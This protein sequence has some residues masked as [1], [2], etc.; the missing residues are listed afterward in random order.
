M[1][2]V[3]LPHLL[4]SLVFDF[5]NHLNL[6]YGTIAE[7]CTSINCPSMSAGSQ[8]EY[9]WSDAQKKNVK[10]SAPQYIDFVMSWVQ[11]VVDDQNMFPTRAGSEFPKDFS[12]TVKSICKK[13]FRVFAHMYHSHFDKILCLQ[14]ECHFNTL[15]VHFYCFVQEFSLID[16]KEFIPL[17]DFITELNAHGTM[18]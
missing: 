10:V 9:L 7:F 2:G 1:T 13:L 3:Y 11:T 16:K 15:F 5:F 18:K 14:E 4:I 17:N 12:S 6:F 8:T